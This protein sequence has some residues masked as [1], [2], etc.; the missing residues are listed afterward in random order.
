MDLGA[1]KPLL[2][3]LAMPPASLLLLAGLGLWMAMRKRRGGLGLTAFSIA[4]LAA[5]SCHGTAVWMA[6]HALPQFPPLTLP[7]LQASKVQA[8]VVLGGGVLPQAPEYGDAQPNTHTAARLR[9]GLWL[10]RQTGLPV[11]FSGGYGWAAPDGQSGSEA[12]VAARVAWQEHGLRLRWTEGRSRDTT[13][14]AQ[15]LAPLLKRDGVQR[16]A[17][18][19]DAS[20]MA[21]AALAFERAGLTVLPAPVDYTLSF[22][23]DLLEWTP[24]ASGLLASR[25]VLH[26]LLAL[27]VGRLLPV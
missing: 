9:Y 12:E 2:S 17:L 26:E 4:L 21:R 19:T 20:H 15:L 3:A 6:S 14:N 10:A 16:M 13:E 18:V 11:A 22:Q 24:S 27:W 7:H 25:Q 8:I 5:L 23:R 1:L